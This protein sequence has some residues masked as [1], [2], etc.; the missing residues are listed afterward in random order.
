MDVK[1]RVKGI[2]T[3]IGFKERKTPSP[4]PPKAACEIPPEMYVVFLK[5]TKVPMIAARRE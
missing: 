3:R 2:A 4:R 5:T 1:M